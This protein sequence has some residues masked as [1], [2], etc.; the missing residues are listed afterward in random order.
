MNG[1]AP[2]IIF[3]RLLIAIAI[4]LALIGY[5]SF[6]IGENLYSEYFYDWFG[7][8]SNSTVG[9]Y[10][11]A[12]IA[13]QKHWL[14]KMC[15]SGVCLHQIDWKCGFSISTTHPVEFDSESEDFSAR[16]QSCFSLLTKKAPLADTLEK[17]RMLCGRRH[18]VFADK[19]YST[20]EE[21]AQAGGKWGEKLKVYTDEGSYFEP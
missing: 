1:M 21:C 6:R 18:M 2:R 4:I 15:H 5:A 8:K 13:A 3:K 9:E 17:L 11:T 10:R 14:K 19:L 20:P 16:V 12:S 7:L